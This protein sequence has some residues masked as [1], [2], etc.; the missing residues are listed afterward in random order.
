MLVSELVAQAL[1]HIG[2]TAHD[3]PATAEQLGYGV[4]SYNGMMRGLRAG[5]LSYVHADAMPTDAVALGDEYT[6]GLM[7]MLAARLAP[8]FGLADPTPAETQRWRGVIAGNFMVIP[9][10]DVSLPR[11]PTRWRT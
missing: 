1:R 2:V 11:R 4:A 5:N 7:H 8:G 10:L 6:D 9:T 3:E